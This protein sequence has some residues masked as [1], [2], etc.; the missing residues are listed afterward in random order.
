[1]R[2]NATKELSTSAERAEVAL[3]QALTEALTPEAK[4]RVIQVLEKLPSAAPHPATLVTIRSLEVLEII[5]TLE[6]RNLIEEL[7]RDT[8]DPIRKREAERTLKRMQR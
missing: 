3:R 4:R 6:A 1:V 8:G 7:S 5:N 2:E